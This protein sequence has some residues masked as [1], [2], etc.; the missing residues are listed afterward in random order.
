MANDSSY[1]RSVNVRK[2]CTNRQLSSP[3]NT[4]FVVMAIRCKQKTKRA[5]ID[6]D[7]MKRDVNESV[8]EQK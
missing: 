8:A 7:S 2:E 3:A 6:F 1:Y 4:E 5:N